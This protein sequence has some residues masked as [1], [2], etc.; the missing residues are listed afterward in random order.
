MQ[1]R[2]QSVAPV[3]LVAALLA[4]SSLRAQEEPAKAESMA[5]I[6]EEYQTASD[7]W[8]SAYRSASNEERK[9]LM[10]KRPEA[11]TWQPRVQRILESEPASGDGCAAAIWLVTTARVTGV[12]LDHALEV[13]MEHHLADERLG[14]LMM[15]LS[16]NPAP[17]VDLF[18][19]KA[20]EVADGDVLAKVCFAHGSHLKAAA[21]AASRLAGASPEEKERYSGYYGPQAVAVLSQADAGELEKRAAKHFE[22]ILG[23]EAMSAVAHYRGTL[24]E[25]AE[26]NL[27]EL[28]R[29]SIGKVAPDIVGEDID[30]VPMKLSD[31]RGKVV[32]IDFWGDW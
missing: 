25:A 23:D 26:S 16:R 21:S 31:Y 7:E 13:I 20:G 1:I 14:D 11:A 30:G 4:P 10:A 18:L 12:E 2:P 6:A 19:S 24:G 9:T 3:L 17:S 8:M 5:E 29:L 15:T 28:Q 22:R 27:F 32:V